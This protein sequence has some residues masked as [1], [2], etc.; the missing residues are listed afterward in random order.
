M[1]TKTN[2]TRNNGSVFEHLINCKQKV[3]FSLY[4]SISTF[5][6]YTFKGS[7]HM[8]GELKV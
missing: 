7:L 4:W 6:G 2:S 8:P 5:F 1:D 3:E